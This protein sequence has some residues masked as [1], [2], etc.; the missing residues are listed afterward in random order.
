M[1]NQAITF[2]KGKYCIR[3]IGYA[4]A[5]II[6]PDQGMKWTTLNE[7]KVYYNKPAEAGKTL[8]HKPVSTGFLYQTPVSTGGEMYAGLSRWR[9][10]RWFQPLTGWVPVSNVGG[11]NDGFNR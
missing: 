10:R 8:S 5:S 11:M 2:Q 4:Q 1:R 9:D 7:F 6:H 3:I